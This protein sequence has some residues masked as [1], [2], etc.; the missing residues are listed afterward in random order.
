MIPLIPGINEQSQA[1]I[2]S[3]LSAKQVVK[4]AILFGSRAKGNY[5]PGSDIDIAI[6]GEAVDKDII[7]TLNAAFEESSLIYFVDIIAYNYITNPDLRA[8]I[9][10]VG[11]T[12]FKQETSKE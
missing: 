10:R 7:S 11:K 5:K 3:I 8:H 2:L 12:I 6:K 1:I 4:E 9:D